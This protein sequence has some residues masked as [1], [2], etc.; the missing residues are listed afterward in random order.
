[1]LNVR[2]WS[3]CC[4]AV[5]M[6]PTSIHED[7][8]SVPGLAQWVCDPSQG[9]SICRGCSPKKQKQKTHKQKKPKCKSLHLL[10]PN[11]Q[12]IPPSLPS[13]LASTRLF[14]MPVSLFLFCRYVHLHHI[15][16]SMYKWYHMVFVFLFLY[17]QLIFDKGAKTLQWG[18]E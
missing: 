10:T 13:P 14:S 15:L 11:S 7:T 6:N 16:D 3:S 5:E 2:V 17:T 9:T 1:M 4:G 18:K 12:S 8:G